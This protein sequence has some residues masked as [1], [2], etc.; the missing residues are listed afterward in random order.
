[1]CIMRQWFRTGKKNCIWSW[2]EHSILRKRSRFPLQYPFWLSSIHDKSKHWWTIRALSVE[3]LVSLYIFTFIWDLYTSGTKDNEWIAI[4]YIYTYTWNISIEYSITNLQFVQFV[5]L[6]T[7]KMTRHDIFVPGL[8]WGLRQG[9]EALPGRH[10]GGRRPEEDSGGDLGHIQVSFSQ[11]WNS[12]KINIH[13]HSGKWWRA[14]GASLDQR[15]LWQST[16]KCSTDSQ[17]G[18]NGNQ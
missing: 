2:F 9:S 17:I 6:K 11:D 15:T 1:M 12:Q 4:C 14:L 13:N 7:N 10:R 18:N 16:W 5:T 3:W 8:P